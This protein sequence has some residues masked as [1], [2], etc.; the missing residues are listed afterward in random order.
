MAK[1]LLPKEG[2]RTLNLFIFILGTVI[3]SFIN[4]CIYR[5]PRGESVVYPPSHCPWCGYNLELLDLI[6]ILSYLRLRGRCR[7][8]GNKI[9]GQ[10]PLVE[11]LTGI[12]FVFAFSKFGFT[13]EF[14]AEIV[15][16]ICLIISTF[17]DIKHQ[18]IPDKVVLPTAVIGLLLTFLLRLQN[19]PDYFLGSAVGGGI[20]LLIAVLSRGGMGGGDVKLF[21]AV[22]MFLGLRLT[23]LSILLSFIFGSI[24]G[25]ML[26]MLN[27]KK[28]KDAIPFGPFIALGSVISLFMGD[29]IISW[30][31]G[32]F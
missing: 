25:L 26:I 17:I 8:C 10:Y 4:V 12:I 28:I 19:L 22:G 3:G 1:S 18:I 15:L 7:K 20:I 21:A 14:L 5:I 32:F 24:A 11:L 27:L 6:P 2:L 13:F 23:I 9:S 29:R 31:W 30:Y 16:I